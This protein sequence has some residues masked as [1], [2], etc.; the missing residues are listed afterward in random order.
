MGQLRDFNLED[1]GCNI[2]IETGTGHG[3]TLSKAL[4]NKKFKTCYSVDLDSNMVNRARILFKHA[5]VENTLSTVALEKWVST[6]PVDSKILFFLDAHFPGADYHGE[7]YDVNAPNAIP[8]KEELEI[9]KKYRPNSK[10]VIICDDARIYASGPFECG[11]V[12]DWLNVPDGYQFVHDIFPESKIELLYSEH[13]YI[14]IDR[15]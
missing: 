2:Y 5:V 7:K 3:G 12:S 14:V 8:L 6:L 4:A 11:D 15:R 1:Y 10:D 9:I 13:G